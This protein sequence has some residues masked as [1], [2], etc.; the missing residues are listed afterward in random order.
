MHGFEGTEKEWL[1]SLK[2][3]NG[4]D[5]FIDQEQVIEQVKEDL[6]DV[7][8]MKKEGYS[9]IS[10]LDIAKLTNISEGANRVEPSKIN[11]NILIDGKEVTVYN[12]LP[13]DDAQYVKNEDQVRLYSGSAADSWGFGEEDDKGFVLEG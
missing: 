4:V 6:K 7:F 11:G 13:L 12:G 2:P 5:Y 10:L 9:L 3:K 1:D 8:V